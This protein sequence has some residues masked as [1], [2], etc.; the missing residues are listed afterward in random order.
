MSG[1]QH[2]QQ[3]GGGQA[4]LTGLHSHNPHVPID[5]GLNLRLEREQGAGATGRFDRRAL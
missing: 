1:G 2:A 4:G 5:E 3:F